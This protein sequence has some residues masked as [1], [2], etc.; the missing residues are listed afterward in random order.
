MINID[1]QK[2]EKI[3]TILQSIKA[4]IDRLEQVL[5]DTAPKNNNTNNTNPNTNTKNDE[6]ASEGITGYFD[7]LFMVSSNGKK[8]EVPRN[9]AAK[10]KLVYGDVLKMIQDEKGANTFK[11]VEKQPRKKIEGIAVKKDN[12]WILLSDA[13][14]YELSSTAA[15]FKN[16]QEHD[17]VTAFIP[18]NNSN[19][20]YAALDE[21]LPTGSENKQVEKPDIAGTD[22]TKNSAANNTY[23]TKKTNEGGRSNPI[24]DIKDSTNNKSMSLNADDKSLRTLGD[25]DLR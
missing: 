24:K 16:V 9:Y 21:V 17:E 25:D 14:A 3:T 19:V 22:S 15:E 8:Y 7:G 1:Q 23:N 13:G 5:F 10:S 2:Q 6:N 18:D 12:A 11:Q 20:P 4:D